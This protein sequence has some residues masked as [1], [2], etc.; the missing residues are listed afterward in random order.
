MDPEVNRDVLMQASREWAKVSATGD[1][2]LIVSFWADDAIVMPPDQ[3]AV[4]GKPAIREYVLKSLAVPG[5]SMTWEPEKA[6]IAIGG[7]LGYIVERNRSTFLDASGKLRTQY[8]KVMT[9]WRKDSSTQWKCVI[10]IW[11][12][13]PSEYV[14]F[15]G[16]NKQHPEKSF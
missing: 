14:L 15:S 13:N 5:F 11:N 9:I 12:G 2:D 3:S 4:V 10:D 7:D 8:G 6:E 1:V 16:V